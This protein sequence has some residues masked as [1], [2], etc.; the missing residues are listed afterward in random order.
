MFHS[1]LYLNQ[2]QLLVSCSRCIGK[3]TTAL[4]ELELDRPVCI[5]RYKDFRDLGRFMLRY[6][7]STI[8]AGLVTEVGDVGQSSR[9]DFSLKI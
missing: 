3:H 7:G 9:K 6:S 8:A 5:E 2:Y 1:V 4:V